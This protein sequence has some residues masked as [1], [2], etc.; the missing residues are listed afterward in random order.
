MKQ[1]EVHWISARATKWSYKE[2]LVGRFETLLKEL[3]LSRFVRK[4]EPVAIKTH[5][6]SEGAHRVVRPL[7]LRKVVESVRQFGG[8]PFVTDT[9]RIKGLEY[10]EVANANGIN[11]LS[12]G[13]PVVMADG[14]FGNDNVAVAAGEEQGEVLVASA[15]YDVPAMIVVS[16]FKGH[17]NAGIGGAIKNIAMGGLSGS[18]RNHDWKH[19]RGGMHAH[20]T[21]GKITWDQEKC[22][23]CNQ[24]VEICPL[25]ACSFDNELFY[26][27]QKKCWRCGRCAR[28]CSEGALYMPMDDDRF[29]RGLAESA[30]AV[31]STFKENRVLYMNFLLEIQPEC[32][33]MP[34][35]DV[36]V[37]Q[38]L[39]ILVSDDVVAVEQASLDLIR[40][41]APLPG[42]LAE[43]KGIEAGEDVLFRL[44]EIDGQKHIDAAAALGLG[45]K[46]YVLME[47][48]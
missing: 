38:D 42:S 11:A 22:V 29:H 3:P 32:D 1:S 10:L 4:K 24:C 47:H 21:E 31:L 44:H 26:Y 12:C 40:Q 28:V 20:H 6:G 19:G 15:I 5:F 34:I 16:H 33:C 8:K 2:S 23:L 45:N 9:V 36:P 14:L 39:G 43:D 41:S 46:A 27:N 35:A 13:A 25:D 17:V 48:P 7:F 37:V 30:K 18:S